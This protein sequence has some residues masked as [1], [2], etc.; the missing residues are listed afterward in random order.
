MA[1]LLIDKSIVRGLLKQLARKDNFPLDGLIDA[2]VY[3]S[4][5]S[6]LNYIL[7]ITTEPTE[8]VYQ[9]D[10][11]KFKYSEFDALKEVCSY[12]D[13]V[14]SG[15]AEDGYMFGKV[16]EDGSWRSEYNPFEGTVKLKILLPQDADSSDVE[17]T[18]S[19]TDVIKIDKYDIPYFKI[20][21]DG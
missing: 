10:Y 14:D 11:V 7:K 4:S 6:Q 13:C 3:N 12:A 18:L 17:K 8:L 20:M 9:G 2:L 15:F 21:K 1:R 16:Q 5:D 19:T